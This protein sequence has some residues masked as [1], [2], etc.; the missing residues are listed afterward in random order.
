MSA[1]ALLEAAARLGITI[2]TEGERLLYRPKSALT[3]ELAAKLKANKAEL[4]AAL[5][6]PARHAPNSVTGDIAAIL[7]AENVAH[8]ASR[9]LEPQGRRVI[10][11]GFPPRHS[12]PPPESILALPR[13]TCPK[14][15]RR[16]VMPELGDITGGTCWPCWEQGWE[17]PQC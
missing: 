4:L 12:E 11:C 15:G 1:T 7:H 17:T 5:S 9:D 8:S 3:P 16:A 2:W 13:V 6:A 10:N 14:C